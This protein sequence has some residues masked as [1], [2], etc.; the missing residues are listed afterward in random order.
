MRIP[1]TLLNLTSESRDSSQLG[2]PEN[3]KVRRP[4]LQ[5]A[6]PAT[7]FGGRGGS[8][9][10]LVASPEALA[11]RQGKVNLYF[12]VHFDRFTVQQIRLVLPLLNSF[13]RRWSEH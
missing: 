12:S 2:V 8:F 11:S 3:E 5:K 13:D 10:N 9:P 6:L 4:R 7:V 1:D